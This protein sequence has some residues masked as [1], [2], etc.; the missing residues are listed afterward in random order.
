MKYAVRMGS[1]AMI[2][3]PS[4]TKIDSGMQ[5]LKEGDQQKHTDSMGI[6]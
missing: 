4:F 1:G 5:K 6:A 2:Y 3:T